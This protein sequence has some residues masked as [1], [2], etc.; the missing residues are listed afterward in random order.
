MS[1]NQLLVAFLQKVFGCMLVSLFGFATMSL[2]QSIDQKS[3]IEQNE[4]AIEKSIS[5]N[6]NEAINMS[7]HASYVNE[8]FDHIA[9]NSYTQDVLKEPGMNSAFFAIHG[10]RIIIAAEG[11]QRVFNP[12]K[13][14]PPRESMPRSDLINTS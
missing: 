1:T 9:E 6:S 5:I 8:A 4:I 3:M 12:R 14:R 10:E 13:I 11:T 2:Y 7:A